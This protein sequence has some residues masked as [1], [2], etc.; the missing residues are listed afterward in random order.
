MKR[1][2]FTGKFILALRVWSFVIPFWK[3]IV[4]F[5]FSHPVSEFYIEIAKSIHFQ[6]FY[7]IPTNAALSFPTTYLVSAEIYQFTAGFAKLRKLHF[8]RI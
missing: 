7:C 8:T 4:L 6:I 5:F 3:S 2:N 1:T